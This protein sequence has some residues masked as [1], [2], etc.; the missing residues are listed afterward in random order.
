MGDMFTSAGV[1]PLL[2]EIDTLKARIRSLE[3]QMRGQTFQTPDEKDARIAKLE[4]ALK[5]AKREI[6]AGFLPT[7]LT[8][9]DDA[10]DESALETKGESNGS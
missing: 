4:A 1:D 5:A 3:S 9:I 7:A 8:Y 6:H 2:D 10:I